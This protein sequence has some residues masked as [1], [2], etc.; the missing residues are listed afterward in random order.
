MKK[1]HAFAL[2]AP[3]ALSACATGRGG[4]FA[5]GKKGELV[6]F[7]YSWP[8]EATAILDGLKD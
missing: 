4:P 8:A 5:F 7:S 3:L 1:I 6:D 2:L